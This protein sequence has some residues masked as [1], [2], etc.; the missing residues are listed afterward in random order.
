LHP[1]TVL[2]ARCPLPEPEG[3]FGQDP[4][5]SWSRSAFAVSHRL[6][7]LLHLGAA[8]LLHPATGHEVRRVSDSQRQPTLRWP[9]PCAPFPRRGSHPSKVPSPAAVPRHRGLLPSCRC[10]SLRTRPEAVVRGS[11]PSPRDRAGHRGVWHTEWR[12][13]TRPGISTRRSPAAEATSLSSR[14]GVP[15]CHRIPSAEADITE[16]LAAPRRPKAARS[17]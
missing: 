4:P 11:L 5:Q 12:A 7:G 10:R 17:R 16:D 6:D 15:C 2:H 14:C 1:S 13:S 9:A 8:G 3:S